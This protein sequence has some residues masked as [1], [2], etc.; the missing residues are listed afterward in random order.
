MIQVHLN[1]YSFIH[2]QV[3]DGDA[4]HAYWGRPEDMKMHRPAYKI[5]ASKPGS[6][7]AGETAAAMAAGYILFKNSGNTYGRNEYIDY[8][9]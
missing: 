9:K 8:S 4:D 6:D 1:P 3:G 5:T 2:L 7:L